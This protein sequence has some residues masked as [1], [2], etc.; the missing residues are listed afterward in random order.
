MPLTK[1]GGGIGETDGMVIV[2]PGDP[3]KKISEEKP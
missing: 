3:V 1:G 2:L